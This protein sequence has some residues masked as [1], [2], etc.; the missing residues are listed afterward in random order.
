M[1]TWL[2]VFATS[3]VITYTLQFVLLLIIYLIAI[4]TH[5]KLLANIYTALPYTT[6]TLVQTLLGP[7]YPIALTLFYYDQRIRHEGFD[8]ERMMETSGMIA[9]A[10]P[11][12]PDDLS[13][14]PIPAEAHS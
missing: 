8:I 3:F 9:T 2:L 4:A 1:F 5:L 12:L 13:A 7:I 14:S 6:A 10:T 11:P